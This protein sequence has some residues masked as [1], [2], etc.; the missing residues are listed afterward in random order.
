MACAG[1]LDH[2]TL[3]KV[4]HP[5]TLFVVPDGKV[6]L[7]NVLKVGGVLVTGAMPDIEFVDG[8]PE[9]SWDDIQVEEYGV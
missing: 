4:G 5:T 6:L 8:L 7:W 2:W 1:F 3:V 9:K